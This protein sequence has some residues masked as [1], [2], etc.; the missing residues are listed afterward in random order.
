MRALFAVTCA[1]EALIAALRS[2]EKEHPAD[3]GIAIS[4]A[5]ALSQLLGGSQAAALSIAREGLAAADSEGL[6]A[7]DA[8]LRVIAVAAALGAGDLDAA[9]GELKAWRRRAPGCAAETASCSITCA[10]GERPWRMTPRDASVKR[11]WRGGCRRAGRPVARMPG[12]RQVGAGA[13]R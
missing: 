5:A 4:I 2:G 6:H 12:A 1:A 9:R 11:S 7:Y 13:G 8:W 10:G 3:T